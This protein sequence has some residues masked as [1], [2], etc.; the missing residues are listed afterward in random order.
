VEPTPHIVA[1]EEPVLFPPYCPRTSCPYHDPTFA[2]GKIWYYCTKAFR[3][4]SRGAIPTF[5]CKACRK[6][7][8]TQTFSV[9]YWTHAV[10]N[11]EHIENELTS[12]NSIRQIARNCRCSQSVIVNRSHRL[13]RQYLTLYAL[14]LAGHVMNENGVFDGFESFVSSQYH[15]TNI[16]YMVGSKSEAVYGMNITVM[17]RKG[18]M[19]DEQKEMRSVI[20]KAWRPEPGAL[21]RSVQE[22]ME[23]FTP[24]IERTLETTE[25]WEFITDCKQEYVEALH[26]IVAINRALAEKRMT[27]VQ[28]SSKLPRTH[29]NPLWPVNYIDREIRKDLGEHVRETVKH[30]RELNHQMERM[31]IL[32]GRHTFKKPR[33]ITGHARIEEGEPPHAV[34]AGLTRHPKVKARWSW[35]YTHRQLFSHLPKERTREDGTRG[36]L[37]WIEQIWQRLYENP[38]LVNLRTGELV[39]G[40]QPKAAWFPQHLLA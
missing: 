2:E 14:A 33:R 24:M 20:D 6:N 32:L 31:V 1:K 27:H 11:L 30:G 18:R 35:L 29:G 38:P 19:S 13:A 23:D 12:C 10:G 39:E 37:L 17:R 21:R 5:R 22:I 26:R 25:N 15:P 8:S 7:C 4:R 40:H 34:R 3:T 16:H 28:V 36:V 9:H